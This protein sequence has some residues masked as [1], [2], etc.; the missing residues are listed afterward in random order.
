[1]CWIIISKQE[2]YSMGSNY[3][4]MEKCFSC[5]ENALF[6]RWL[7]CSDGSLGRPW[8][9]PTIPAWGRTLHPALFTLTITPSNST[10]A[11]VSLTWITWFSARFPSNLRSNIYLVKVVGLRLRWVWLYQLFA[12]QSS[13]RKRK[14]ITPKT[15]LVTYNR[16]VKWT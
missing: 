1:M 4:K 14:R 7:L 2:Y 3:L 16:E 10:P 13:S 6:P 11:T 5:A 12:G 8:L 15:F 9:R